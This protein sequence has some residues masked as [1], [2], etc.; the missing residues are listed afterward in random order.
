MEVYSFDLYEA[1][2]NN[3]W[4]W[5]TCGVKKLSYLP[6]ISKLLRYDIL[7]STTAAG[8]GH[9]TSSLSAVELMSTLFFGGF[10]KY[11]IRNPQ[12]FLNDRI[13]FSKGHASPL[14]YSLYH[15]A[16]VISY[17]E[18]L[19]LRK[20]DSVLEGHPTPRF[21]YIDVSTGSLGQGLSV[22]VGMAL[23]IKLKFE[24]RS[25][26]LET[27]SNIKNS[28]YQNVSDSDIRISD[29]KQKLPKVF[30]LL[31]D[32]EM[33]EGQVWEAMEIASYYK[34]S[35][36]IAILD[37]NRLGQRGETMLG[38][39]LETYAKRVEAFG[40]KAVIV[41]DGNDLKQVY[42]TYESIIGDESRAPIMVIAKT[43]K[44]KGVSFLENKDGWHGKAVPKEQLQE[45]LDELGEVDL[46][47]R[48]KIQFPKAQISKLKDQNK[49]SNLKSINYK[50]QTTNYELG[51]LVAT[52]EAYGEALTALGEMDERIVALDA[53]TSNSTYADK[54]GKRFPQR[55]FEMFIAEQNMISAALGMSKQGYIP[56]ASSFAAFLT[57]AF[58]QIR[59]SQYSRP[60]I[61]I[62]GSHAGVSI[63]SDGPSQMALE[64]LAM[65]R[66]VLHSIVFYPS[67]ATSTFRLTEIMAKTAG[68]FYMRTTR[69][70]T[71]ILYKHDETFKIAGSK[72]LRQSPQ[73]VAVVFAAGITVH[74]ALKAADE[75][76]EERI[77]ICIVDLYSLKPIDEKTIREQAKK[78]RNII[79]VEDH[80]LYGGI[81]E[82]VLT[83]LNS[84]TKARNPRQIQNLN[85]KNS[86]QKGFEH[87]DLRNSNI[88]SSFDIRISN[89]VHL[90]VRKLPRSGTPEELL[91]YE[92]INAAAII[93][94]V[95]SL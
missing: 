50:L 7:T 60:N 59:M 81:G 51:S 9:P 66:S 87:L 18:L 48:G 43:I 90:C 27:N 29:L 15:A 14:V 94:A 75:L 31:G 74:E 11:D 72:L 84:N 78:C 1:F 73:D 25:S 3:S 21:K 67:D 65:M 89:F 5:Y 32:S 64:D 4:I 17:D 77:S 20:F 49:I 41:K 38:W 13:I 61:K 63:G 54:F 10:L 46:N 80:Y 95:K 8:S 83:A 39:N 33:A 92:E 28:N 6:S 52:R 76:K 93:K 56:F 91:A 53:E 82:A 42:K 16:G 37:V 26:K 57:R 2:T 58:D 12:S 44:G 62:V 47:V 79:V 40:W 22:G 88:V 71:P 85:D 45:A 24:A 69:E 23:G 36:L 86:K 30:V 68:L 35:N 70:K 19:T 55:F 34:L